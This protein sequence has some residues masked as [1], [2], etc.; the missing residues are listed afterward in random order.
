MGLLGPVV[1]ACTV[2]TVVSA[3]KQVHGHLVL[4]HQIKKVDQLCVDLGVL[5]QVPRRKV[6][7]RHPACTHER[8]E[9]GLRGRAS[10][11]RIAPD[12]QAAFRS[13][14]RAARGSGR[15]VTGQLGLGHERAVACVVVDR[16]ATKRRSA[17]KTLLH[18]RQIRFGRDRALLR[19][20]GPFDRAT[21]QVSSFN[22]R[23]DPRCSDH[24]FYSRIAIEHT[25]ERRQRTCRFAAELGWQRWV[26]AARPF[27][28]GEHQ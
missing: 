14:R 4:R 2:T 25:N 22:R 12:K 10:D 23:H 21:S 1:S 19:E 16:S 3:I 6:H 17:R 27:T 9:R 11:H 26:H 5:D 13:C 18:R 28:T 20:S 24:R 8:E 7:R 15:G